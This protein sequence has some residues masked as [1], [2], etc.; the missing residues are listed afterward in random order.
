M[1]ISGRKYTG[2]DFVIAMIVS[3]GC[4]L[5]VLSGDISH[6]RT[7]SD[8]FY[9]LFLMILYLFS[10]GFTST[11]QENLFRGSDMSTYNQ[12]LYVNL[13]SAAISFASLIFTDELLPSIEFSYKHLDFFWNSFFLSLT[14]AGGQIVIL[15]T[16]KEFGALFFASVMTLRQVVSILL[17]CLIYLHPLSVG[18][19]L[20]AA[21]VFGAI[22]YRDTRMK[23]SHGHGGGHHRVVAASAAASAAPSPPPSPH[24]GPAASVANHAEPKQELESIRIEA[25]LQN[26]Q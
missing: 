18:Q 5:F 13:C 15:M 6:R 14:S 4:A 9:G 20:C 1:S 10:D 12:M 25:K 22:Y 17:S 8:T 7:K 26:S 16:I 3:L 11:L 24:T 2:K 21:I 19:W 23:A